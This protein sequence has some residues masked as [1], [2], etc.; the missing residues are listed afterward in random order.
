MVITYVPGTVTGPTGKQSSA[1]FLID[2]A[3]RIRCFQKPFGARSSSRMVD[4]TRLE[5][6]VSGCA[7]RIPQGDVPYTVILGA[8]GD[9]Q[10]LLG[11]VTLEELGLVF[12]PFKRE[13][14]PAE[15][16]PI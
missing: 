7:L 14:Y 9:N 6:Q 10:A 11:V 13:L 5:R 3:P 15:M 2:T 1:E 8:S 12:H 4:G 16:L